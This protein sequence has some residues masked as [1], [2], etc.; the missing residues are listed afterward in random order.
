MALVAALLLA[1]CTPTA[2]PVLSAGDADALARLQAYLNGLTRFEAHFTQTGSFG[3]GAGLV[4]L[5]RPGHLRIDYAGPGGRVMVIAGGR[6]RVLDRATGSTTTMPVSRTPL[7][8]LLGPS[9]DLS[10][11][12]HVESLSR[13]PGQERLVLTRAA[14]PALGTLT[15]DFASL[16][17]RLEAVSVTDPYHRVLT[18]QL[19]GIETAPVITPDLFLPPAS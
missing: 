4:W 11:D 1:A 7:G 13:T 10:G 12:A 19:T 14:Q 6:V 17:L 18:L 9:I 3:E 8:L 15:L 16:P 5:D 2:R